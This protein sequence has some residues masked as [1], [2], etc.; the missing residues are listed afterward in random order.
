MNFSNKELEII[1]NIIESQNIDMSIFCSTRIKRNIQEPSVQLLGIID[2]ESVLIKDKN[3]KKYI[4]LD[5]ELQNF[6][7]YFFLTM[8]FL[9]DK[10]SYSAS[11]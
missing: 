11:N 3:G 2:E 6:E 1:N 7:R 9:K 4:I 10:K 8:V 5:Q